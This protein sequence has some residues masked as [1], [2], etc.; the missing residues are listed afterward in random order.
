M[1]HAADY[2][3]LVHLRDRS[4]PQPLAATSIE[5]LPSGFVRCVGRWQFTSGPKANRTNRYSDP[6]RFVFPADQILEIRELSA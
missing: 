5:Y 3:A 4:H 1:S 2:I 6:V